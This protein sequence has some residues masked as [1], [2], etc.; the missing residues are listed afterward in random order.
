MKLEKSLEEFMAN[1]AKARP[2]T[3]YLEP[4]PER[5]EEVMA[6]MRELSELIW[7]DAEDA[8]I[9]IE[10]DPLLGTS[11]E[12]NVRADTITFRDM[13]RFSTAIEAASNFI[14]YPDT[15]GKQNFCV[16]YGKV[17]KR[18]KQ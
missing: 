12:L 18:V 13:D 7:L 6:S 10:H 8:E 9:K 4:I 11:L 2:A 17:Y 5:K 15:D 16:T 3:I 1:F 14:I